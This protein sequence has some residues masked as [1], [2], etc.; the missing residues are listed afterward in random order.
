MRLDV[1]VPTEV[2]ESITQQT[3]TNKTQI[4]SEIKELPKGIQS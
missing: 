4:K 3:Y 1:G 2:S